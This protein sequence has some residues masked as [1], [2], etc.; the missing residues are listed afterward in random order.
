MGAKR[1]RYKRRLQGGRAVHEACE[2]VKGREFTTARR[3]N[4][5]AKVEKR[6]DRAERLETSTFVA[7]LDNVRAGRFANPALCLSSTHSSALQRCYCACL[8]GERRK[9]SDGTSEEEEHDEFIVKYPGTE[10][11]PR[12]QE[13]NRNC[14]RRQC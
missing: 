12:H 3:G 7:E 8:W 9:S 11:S 14:K 13:I 1:K 5:E 10:R 4:K 2:M 6:C